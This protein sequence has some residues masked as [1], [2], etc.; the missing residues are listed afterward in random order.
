MVEEVY[1]DPGQ[2]L[3]RLDG[4][5]EHGGGQG[6]RETVGDILEQLGNCPGLV[7][8]QMRPSLQKVVH[9]LV[10]MARHLVFSSKLTC[11]WG[12]SF[13]WILKSLTKCYYEWVISCIESW[14]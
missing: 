5:L 10:L 7:G 12:S 6:G 3:D 2:I 1:Q 4:V 14:I 11:E 8:V 9:G 13:R